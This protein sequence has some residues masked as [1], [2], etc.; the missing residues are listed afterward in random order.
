[1]PLLLPRLIKTYFFH[2]NSPSGFLPHLEVSAKIIALLGEIRGIWT[3]GLISGQKRG[4]TGNA[5]YLA[6]A[7]SCKYFGAR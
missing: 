6:V 3:I 5:L 1:M 2:L 7:R 4:V